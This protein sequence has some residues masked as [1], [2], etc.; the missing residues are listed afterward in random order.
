MSTSLLLQGKCAVVFG[1]GGSIGAAVAK[2]FASQGAEV[3]LAGRTTT[4][5]EAVAKQIEADG[6]RAHA[7]VIDALDSAAVDEY[8]HSVVQQTGSLD[9]EFNAT[10]PRV[11][12]YA[13][14]KPIG[15]LPVDEFMV[16]VNTV[17][18]ANFIT[19]SAAARHM[20][21]QGSGVIIFL[22]GSP[23]QPHTP[24]SA[25]IGAA[26]GAIENL[27]RHMAIDL[28]PAGV[29]VVCVRTAANPDSRT[30]QDLTDEMAKIMNIT[31]DQARANLADST[32][33][34]VSPRTTDT[35]RAA[36]LVASDLA[37]MMTG[38]VLN[39]SAGVVPD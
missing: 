9:V 1:G 2:E 31:S 39:A 34:K 33:L 6:G 38:T 27:T 16:P 5:V 19:A 3:F 13:N 22:T 28:S 12:E 14:G 25:A 37:R 36:A 35:A 20:L 4:S 32:L 21:K 24:G 17:L 18:K 23:A 15:S 10:G 8:C 30:I 7:D 26:F 11:S 29:R